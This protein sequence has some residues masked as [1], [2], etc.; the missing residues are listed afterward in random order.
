MSYRSLALCVSH[1]KQVEQD[2][3]KP[4]KYAT[5]KADIRVE[6]EKVHTAEQMAAGVSV[7][8]PIGL[9]A[10]VLKGAEGTKIKVATGEYDKMIDEKITE[11]KSECNLE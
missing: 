4:V 5:A 10:G 9:V 3:K 7:I 2:L 11:I 1:Y 8:V 6:N